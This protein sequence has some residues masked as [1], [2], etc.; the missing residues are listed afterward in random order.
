MPEYG[1]VVVRDMTVADRA[2]FP[3]SKVQASE[4]VVFIEVKLSSVGSDYAAVA[5]CLRK[6][7]REVELDQFTA[8]GLQLFNGDVTAIR[9]REHLSGDDA[10]E[11]PRRL[12]GT[13]AGPDGEDG[14]QVSLRR[15]F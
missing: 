10:T 3:I 11:M 7:E 13:Q 2:H 5:P 14:Q 1:D 9:E 12:Y 6:I 8:R 15:P 4:H